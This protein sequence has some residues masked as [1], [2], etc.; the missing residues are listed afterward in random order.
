MGL[1]D[2]KQDLGL[3]EDGAGAAVALDF[4]R[5]GRVALAGGVR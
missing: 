5:I 3:R 2:V 1:D 4:D